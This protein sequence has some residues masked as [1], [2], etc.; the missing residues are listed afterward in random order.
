MKLYQVVA[1]DA[2]RRRRRLLY[3]ALGVVVGV[4]VF[5]SVLTI[6]DAGENK[7][8]KELDKYGANLMVTPAIQ[9]VGLNLGTLELGS[10]SV[11]EN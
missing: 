5:I 8:Y 2:L 1:K 9:D 4:A 6:A 3:T 11:G 7:I 10:L